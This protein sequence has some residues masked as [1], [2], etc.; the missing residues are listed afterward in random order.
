MHEAFKRQQN[1]RASER[2]WDATTV[3]AV[4]AMSEGT[5]GRGSVLSQDAMRH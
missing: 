1:V 3:G 5:R 4:N 2:T